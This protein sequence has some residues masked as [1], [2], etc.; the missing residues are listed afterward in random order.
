MLLH[1]SSLKYH[2]RLTQRQGLTQTKKKAFWLNTFAEKGYGHVF[3][4]FI[5]KLILT[6]I[7]VIWKV[8]V[9]NHV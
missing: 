4:K 8:I 3:L 1:R 7:L 6:R 9:I 2:G 5:E